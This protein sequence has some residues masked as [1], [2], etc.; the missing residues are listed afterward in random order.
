MK[1]KELLIGRLYEL[2]NKYPQ[3]G[4]KYMFDKIADCH[5]V[6]YGPLDL[7]AGDNDFKVDLF[8]IFE[9][10]EMPGM[11]ED[12]IVIDENDSLGVFAPEL[13][14]ESVI[15]FSHTCGINLSEPQSSVQYDHGFVDESNFAL[16]A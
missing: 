11:N 3:A 6:Q 9:L 10:Y 8:S 7:L 16:A 4:L 14:L 2:H 15:D 13:V 12:L 1:I 5:V